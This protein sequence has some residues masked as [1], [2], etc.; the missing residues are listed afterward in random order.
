MTHPLTPMRTSENIAPAMTEKRLG[1]VVRRLR[2]ERE[3]TQEQLARR[4]GVQQA[5]LSQIESGVRANPTAVVVKKLA[6]ALGVPVG[7]LLE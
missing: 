4:S 7:E 2:R 3:W 1:A 5:H 6:R